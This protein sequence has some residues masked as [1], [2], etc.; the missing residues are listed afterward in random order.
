[1]W[2]PGVG[3]ALGGMVLAAALLTAVMPGIVSE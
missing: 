3:L 1:V 2:L